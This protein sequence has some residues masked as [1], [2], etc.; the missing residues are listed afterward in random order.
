VSAGGVAPGTPL[1]L[2]LDI[3][4]SGG[5]AVLFDAGGRLAAQ[6]VQAW[7]PR[8]PR[9]DWAE[10]DAEAI[11]TATAGLVEAA[12]AQAAPA[13]VAG[14]GIS[15]Q[16]TTL[17][18]DASHAPVFP[19]LPWLDRRAEAEARAL[20]AEAGRE[21]LARVAGRRA[22]AERPAAIVRWVRE[23]EPA[24]WGRT[25]W[26]CTLKDYLVF[27]LTGRL[28]S[29]EP[30]ASYSLLF[31]V[32]A[33]RWDAGLCEL[34]GVPPSRLPEVLPSPA[35]IGHVQPSAA[36]AT[37]LSAG[38]PV[39]AGGP[40][41][42]LATLGAGLTMPAVGV[43]VTGT[44]DVV[45]ACLRE[46]KLDPAGGLVTNVH[47]CPEH[48]LLGGPTTT[49]GGMLAWFAEHIARETDFAR[50][51][52]EAAEIPPGAEG[53]RCFPAL[54]GDRTP[55][56]DPHARAAFIGLGVAHRR[57]HCVR[58]ILEACACV[59]RRVQQAIVGFGE[60]MGEMRVVG[61][62]AESLLWS[63]IRAD[64]LSLPVRPMPLRN[65]S[66]LGAAILAAAGV[67]VHA[68]VAAAAT[69]MSRSGELLWPRPD[70]RETYE[71]LYGEFEGIQRLLQQGERTRWREST[72]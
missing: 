1:L 20:E 37:G 45:F 67:G 21:C 65:A 19:V 51:T 46:P 66:A 6:A 33:K 70:V 49:T 72:T 31:D 34:A 18:L 12:C 3:G 69:A 8:F 56:W 50:L 53:V 35:L 10:L 58:A 47:A 40:D 55:V 38:V 63:Q 68:D 62:A 57:G 28:A 64:M 39:V 32:R 7:A 16:L 15:S 30:H 36:E 43:D 26:V 14:V 17:F 42:T 4:S 5:R 59:V 25:A 2:G 61:G 23:H 24:V 54:S 52:E 29:D 27:R 22:A 11:W 48:W 71:G 9:P 60:K 44:T 41:G 13:R